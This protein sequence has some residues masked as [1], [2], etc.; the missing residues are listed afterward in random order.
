MFRALLILSYTVPRL[1]YSYSRTTA[2]I[3]RTP[4]ASSSPY[5]VLVKPTTRRAR[6]HLSKPRH[7]GPNS[8]G[9][10]NDERSQVPRSTPHTLPKQDGYMLRTSMTYY[11][12]QTCRNRRRLYR[13]SLRQLLPTRPKRRFWGKNRPGFMQG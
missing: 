11:C 1:C 7:P 10:S 2:Q 8:H 4:F 5:F 13:L 9:P 12:P 6:T 3:R